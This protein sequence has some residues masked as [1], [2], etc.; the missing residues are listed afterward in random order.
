M[1]VQTVTVV[2]LERVKG[3]NGNSERIMLHYSGDRTKGQTWRIGA[4]LAKLD[5]ESRK[6][7]LTAEK[8]DKRNITVEKEGN[9]WVL[10]KVE[11]ATDLPKAA[12]AQTYTKVEGRLT[13]VEKSEGAQRGNVLTNAVN[14]TIAQGAAKTIEQT[15]QNVEKAAKLLLQISNKL[16]DN[17]ELITD[18]VIPPADEINDEIGF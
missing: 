15:M 11:P 8:G 18:D 9:Y 6:S 4:F 5:D 17:A 16:A 14:L 1:T 13:D 10:R 7:V 2:D 12:N 3:E